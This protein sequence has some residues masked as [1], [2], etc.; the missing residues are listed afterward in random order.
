MASV[1][2]LDREVRDRALARGLLLERPGNLT[3]PKS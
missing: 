1:S 3:E 2:S